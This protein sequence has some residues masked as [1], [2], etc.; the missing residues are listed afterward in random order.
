M[1]TTIITKFGSGA[2][3]AS[4]VVRGELAVDTENG[5]LYT[6]DSGGSVIEIGLNP[7][8]NVDVTGTVTADGL[9]VDGT[10]SFLA[11]V[12]FDN[13]DELRWK[14]SGGTERTALFLDGSNSL[15]LGTSAGGNLKFY[16]GSSYTER[17]RINSD[18]SMLKVSGSNA[19]LPAISASTIEGEVR[20]VEG[21]STTIDSGLLRLSAGGGT[22]VG[23]KAGIDIF[24]GATDGSLI[25]MFTNGS[26]AMRIDSSGIVRVGAIGLQTSSKFAARANGNNIEF[27]HVNNTGGFYGTI[28]ARYNSGMPYI[29][30]SA[31]DSGNTSNQFT[32]RGTKGNV[33]TNETDGSLS[34]LQVTT[35][36][37]A[38]QTPAE[39][40]RIDSSGNLLVGKTST[41]IGT[42]GALVTN[43]GTF[44]SATATG[45]YSIFNKTTT[46][47][48]VQIQFR[49]ANVSVGDITSTSSATAY[50][51]SSD[52]RL[53]DNIVDAPS[54]SDDIDAIQVRS[55]D[56]KVDGS[57]Q[58]YGMVAQELVT[59]APSAV[60]QPEDPEE[61]MG[62]DYSKLVPMLIKEVQSL[63]AR[64]A[65]LEGAN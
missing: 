18:G 21:A 61:M 54:A 53:K 19:T 7:S 17:L 41:D 12:V 43:Y 63:R 34:F 39:R 14:D 49:S 31:D 35:A 36:N 29:A 32:T 26:E 50:N 45:N 37:A 52:Q 15:N 64:V 46:D 62:V 2:P 4:D 30:F 20:G 25:R 59:V 44:Q 57:H 33:I 24:R 48:G 42:V 60:S 47:T 13:N 28:G 5:R 9:T 51:T 10:T 16:N 58:K 56:W 27:G 23:V 1:A 8:G 55:F 22:T 40:M 11:K 3:T 38:D 65:Q 6:E